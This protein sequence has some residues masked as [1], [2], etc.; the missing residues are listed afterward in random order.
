MGPAI[1]HKSALPDPSNLTIRCFVGDELRQ[2]SS[3]SLMLTGIA[4]IIAEISTGMTLFPGDIIATGTPGGVGMGFSPP[5]YLRRGDQVT[6]E[7]EGIGILHNFI[8]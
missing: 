8:E 2:N 5:K 1:V 6:C 3:T 4:S 7:I